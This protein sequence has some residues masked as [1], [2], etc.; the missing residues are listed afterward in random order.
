MPIFTTHKDRLPNHL[1]YPVG[2]QTLAIA[3]ADVPQAENLPVWFLACDGSVTRAEKRQKDGEYYRILSAEFH[4]YRLGISECRWLESLYEPTWSL[5]VYGVTRKKRA[6]AR[7]LLIE[8]G[9]PKIAAWLTV[10]RSETWLA[11]TKKIAVSF[12]DE[13]ETIIVTEISAP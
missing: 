9:I 5:N 13:Q 7:N 6:V 11:G 2:L 1:S 12:S 8:H 10:P 4:H 3:L